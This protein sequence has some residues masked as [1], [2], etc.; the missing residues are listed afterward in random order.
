MP[1]KQSIRDPWLSFLRELDAVVD[2]E[3]RLDC[4]GGFVVTVVY[5]FSRPTAD[6]DVLEIAPREAAK[7]M[8]DVGMKGGPLHKKYK[9]YLDPV[10]VAHV[11]ENYE[12]RLTQIFPGTFAHLRLCA[13][14]PY[15]LALSKLE[16]NIQRDRDDVKHL[17]KTSPTRSRRLEGALSNGT[18]L[19]AWKSGTRGSNSAALARSNRGREKQ[20]YLIDKSRSIKSTAEAGAIPDVLVVHSRSITK[21]HPHSPVPAI[22][23]Q[24]VMP[25]TARIP[26]AS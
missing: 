11:P 4:M 17:A 7:S 1:S 20:K 6:L 18:A 13:L 22:A 2:V 23:A 24:S 15:D 25:E 10:G 5:G 21:G 14:D 8:L 19:A 9:I 12:E 3:T 26:L 16:R